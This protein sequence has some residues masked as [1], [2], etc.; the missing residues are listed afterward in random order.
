MT[1]VGERVIDRRVQI[2]RAVHHHEVMLDKPGR[3]HAPV[4]LALSQTRGL[5]QVTEHMV[6]LEAGPP[7]CDAVREAPRF[8]VETLA[9][10]IG[11]HVLLRG[12]SRLDEMKGH[13]HL[14]K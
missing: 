4:L 10:D 8:I 5:R 11:E 9:K 6:V 12:G 7:R 13:D 2:E 3:H 1:V 14:A